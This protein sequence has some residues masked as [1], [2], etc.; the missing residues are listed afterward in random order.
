MGTNLVEREERGRAATLMMPHT[1]KQLHRADSES[2]WSE[3]EILDRHAPRKCMEFEIYMQ[4][5]HFGDP[6]VSAELARAPVVALATL[7][8]VQQVPFRRKPSTMTW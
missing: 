2:E 6:M 7:Y 8:Y 5:L 1:E 3:G 4:G